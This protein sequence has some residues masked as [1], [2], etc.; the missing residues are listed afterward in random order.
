MLK[1]VLAFQIEYS[2]ALGGRERR[3]LYLF[4]PIDRTEG[5]FSDVL[6]VFV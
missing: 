6:K 4:F 5:K 2:S 1:S 3:I